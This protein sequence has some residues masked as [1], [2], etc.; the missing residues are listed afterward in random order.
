MSSTAERTTGPLTKLLRSPWLRPFNDAEAIDDLLRQV[1]PTWSLNQVRARVVGLIDETPDT[2]TLVL[3]ANRQWR[4]HQAG[5]HVAVEVDINGALHQRSYSL[6]SQPQ[7]SRRLAITVKRQPGGKVSNFLHDH[8]GLGAVLTLSAPAGDF[9]LPTPAPA[10]LLM[11]SAGSGITPLM[12]QLRALQAAG[13]SGDLVF[14]H[15]ARNRDSAIFRDE[16]EQL[17]GEWPSLKLALHFSAESG[18]LDAAAIARL[19]PDY[20]ER[21]TLL[22]GPQSFSDSLRQHYLAIDLGHRLATESFSG[23]QLRGLELDG[24]VQVRASKSEQVFTSTGTQPLLVEAENA[25]LN[26]KYGCRMGIC[27]S[28]QCLKKSGTVQN[29]LTGEISSAPN[30]LIQLCIST[31]RSDLELGL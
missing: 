8:V 10:K 4:G 31:A 9:V 30:Q 1:H 23:P 13:Y 11:L 22:C 14:V 5:Q 24:A 19:V 15:G 21:Y 29:L 7:D 25:G 20:T 12:S 2:R 28:C 18:R 3:E 26:P 16:L 6:S 27:R 17:A